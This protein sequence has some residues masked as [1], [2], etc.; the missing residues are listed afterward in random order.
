VCAVVQASD[1]EAGGDAED[2]YSSDES[3][4]ETAEQKKL[5][6]GMNPRPSLLTSTP[7][8]I[9]VHAR[10]AAAMLGMLVHALHNMHVGKLGSLRNVPA[11]A[12]CSQGVPGAAEG[13]G[14]SGG[15]LQQ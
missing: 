12:I 14:G 11:T 2:G 3:A 7:G 8:H 4:E 10:R 15:Q 6:I 5:R 1:D 9:P 13:G